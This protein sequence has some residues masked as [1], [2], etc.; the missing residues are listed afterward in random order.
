MK[1]YET[2]TA[3]NWI[4]GALGDGQGRACLIGHL[5]RVYGDARAYF[6]AM[7]LLA[8]SIKAVYP[9]RYSEQATRATFNNHPDTTLEDILRVCKLA[10]V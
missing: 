2:I 10:D 3:E 9:E 4:K 6:E 7:D 8:T 1:L 5:M